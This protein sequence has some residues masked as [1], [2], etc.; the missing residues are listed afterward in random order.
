MDSYSPWGPYKN[1]VHASKIMNW[2]STIVFYWFYSNIDL[3][4]GSY[5]HG[6]RI[7]ASNQNVLPST[8]TDK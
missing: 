7:T 5:G 4:Q 8:E 2:V 3:T 6:F 1:G